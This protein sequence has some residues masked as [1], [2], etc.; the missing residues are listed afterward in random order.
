MTG[1]LLNGRRVIG[2][3]CA[4]HAAPTSADDRLLLEGDEHSGQPLRSTDPSQHPELERVGL[5]PYEQLER[6]RVGAVD[7]AERVHDIDALAPDLT[8]AFDEL[9]H[10]VHGPRFLPSLIDRFAE[11]GHGF[12][13]AG[14][15]PRDLLSGFHP[16]EVGDLDATGTA[17]AGAFCD[18]AEEVLQRD[19][20]SAECPRRFSPDSLVCSILSP[21]RDGHVLDYRGL[22]VSGLPYP[23]TGTDVN[24]DCRQ[25]DL[26]VNTLLYD[27]LHRVVLDPLG[28]ALDDLPH[29]REGPR[30]LVLAG[31]PQDPEICAELLLR[32][33]KFRVRWQQPG[34]GP[35]EHALGGRPEGKPRPQASPGGQRGLDDSAVRAWAQALPADLAARLDERGEAAWRRLRAQADTCLPDGPDTVSAESVHAYGA[36]AVELL[37]RI[38][39]TGT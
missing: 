9:I 21:Q 11:S 25:R 1:D 35:S 32:A 28:R 3:G 24:Q 13:L 17:P 36:V 38:A 7:E 39:G 33:L 30:R 5:R 29:R 14:G 34:D 18:L 37:A 23:A 19:G 4:A 6:N 15:A 2:F 22:G 20:F 31:E 16:D 26:T 10:G 27:P 8:K 12:W